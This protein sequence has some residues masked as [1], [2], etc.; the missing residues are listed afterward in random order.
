MRCQK[1]QQN[2]SRIANVQRVA[3]ENTVPFDSVWQANC[4]PK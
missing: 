3:I 2:L 1:L 4:H